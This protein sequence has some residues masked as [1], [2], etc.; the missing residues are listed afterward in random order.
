MPSSQ[1]NGTKFTSFL[2]HVR[3]EVDFVPLACD[4]AGHTQ[5][6]LILIVGSL[7]MTLSK[8]QITQALIRLQ[9][10]AGLSA[11]LLFPN[12]EEGFSHVD[13]QSHW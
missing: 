9:R 3:N 5:T 10:C 12:S 7:D 2:T 11:P 6:S 1:A 8:E 13:A 4:D